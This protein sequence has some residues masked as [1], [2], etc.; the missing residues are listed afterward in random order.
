ML[1]FFCGWYLVE[2]KTSERGKDFFASTPILFKSKIF[3]LGKGGGVFVLSVTQR[4]VVLVNKRD[5]A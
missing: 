2:K 3:L 4:K 5:K 1:S